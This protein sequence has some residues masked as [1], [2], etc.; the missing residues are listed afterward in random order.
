V[1]ADRVGEHVEDVG[2][3]SVDASFCD[4][5]GWRERA[6]WCGWRGGRFQG[7]L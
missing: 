1:I 4:D 5:D 7:W 6:P 2:Y 3:D